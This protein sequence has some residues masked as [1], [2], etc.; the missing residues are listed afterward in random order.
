MRVQALHTR[1][2][3]IVL[4]VMVADLNFWYFASTGENDADYAGMLLF[5][6]LGLY[7]LYRLAGA[8]ELSCVLPALG[9]FVALGLMITRETGTLD[10]GYIPPYVIFIFSVWAGQ[11]LGSRVKR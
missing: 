5:G 11:P 10:L 6:A 8:R 1:W 7:W 3:P 9:A 4:G 2:L